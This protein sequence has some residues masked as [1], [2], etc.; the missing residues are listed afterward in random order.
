[1]IQVYFTTPCEDQ[2]IRVGD[3]EYIFTDTNYTLP[4]KSIDT[5]TTE[6]VNTSSTELLALMRALPNMGSERKDTTI[7]E[8]LQRIQA[9]YRKAS[10]ETQSDLAQ[11]ILVDRLDAKY[12]SP[13]GGYSLPNKDILIPGANRGYRMDTTDGVHHGW[14]I[15]APHGTPVQ[16]LSKGKII[17]IVDDWNWGYFNILKK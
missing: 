17:R 10:T 14:D 11:S 3:S 7:V 2:G 12:I 9:L 6:F 5:I 13:V 15:M 4:L 16:A 1:M 8:K